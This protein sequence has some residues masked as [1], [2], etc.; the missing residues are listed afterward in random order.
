MSKETSEFPEIE[1]L[2]LEKLSFIESVVSKYRQSADAL[3][4]SV[5]QEIGDMPSPN[6][7][8]APN[9][10]LEI[11]PKLIQTTNNVDSE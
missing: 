3:N 4:S 11:T 1:S 7:L 2:I 9:Q 10:T 6:P 8:T 5:A